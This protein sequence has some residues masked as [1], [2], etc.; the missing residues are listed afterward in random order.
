MEKSDAILRENSETGNAHARFDAWAVES[1][2]QGTVASLLCRHL[3]LTLMLATAFAGFAAEMV[4]VGAS[5]GNWS[6]GANW[7]GE[8]APGASDTAVFELESDTRVIL[9]ADA[10]AAKISVTGARLDLYSR[11]RNTLTLGGETPELAIGA[12]ASLRLGGFALASTAKIKK[13]GAG[14]LVVVEKTASEVDLRHD[15]GEL[16]LEDALGKSVAVSVNDGFWVYDG[17]TG[18]GTVLQHSPYGG[19]DGICAGNDLGE[20]VTVTA[21]TE[22][23][24][25][26]G[27]F[28]VSGD[29]LMGG[30]GSHGVAVVLHNDPR[31]YLARTVCQQGRGLG[32]AADSYDSGAV[33][34]SFAFG[35]LNHYSVGDGRVVWGW[36]GEWKNPSG[37]NG[38]QTVPFIYTSPCG[39]NTQSE[40]HPRSFKLQLDFD[41]VSKTAVLTLVQ[42]QSEIVQ[43]G[44]AA[45]RWTKTLSGIDLTDVCEGDTATLAFTTDAGGRNT[46]VTVSNLK[47]D[48]FK[49]EQRIKEAIPVI[50]AEDLW[51]NC[52]FNADGVEWQGLVY[53]SLDG[54]VHV[55][56]NAGD[57]GS[58][59]ARKE[60]V[61]VKGKFQIS[62]KVTDSGSGSWGWALVLHNDP[63][64]CMAHAAQAGNSNMAFSGKEGKVDRSY[65][66]R[67]NN[68]VRN[69]GE[70]ADGR[71]GV[72][73]QARTTN[74]L[75]Q[76]NPYDGT[77]LVAGGRNTTSLRC[78]TSARRQ[79]S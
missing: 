58:V 67:I 53:G 55:G 19:T 62:G 54:S 8:K 39:S 17:I 18:S 77:Q 46:A 36:D 52:C 30:M 61:G 2:T 28:R 35:I 1:Q 66:F 73:N 6:D 21:R 10:M 59:T 3:A 70:V 15:E 68:Y 48:Y 27:R 51:T 79:W 47:V 75:I 56:A 12:G 65:A 11:K 64:G 14:R 74:P 5:G 71:N 9:A 13:T 57:K 49:T 41:Q 43:D 69:K 4:W 33:R 20:C 7:K 25:I 44:D 45:V 50:T 22:P 31:G 37:E 60:K 23:I 78:S 72:W 42:D 76:T 16:M 29:V 26:N 32:Y 24:K 34:K 38:E 63:R 40:I